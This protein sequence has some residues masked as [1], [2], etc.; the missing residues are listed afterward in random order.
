[1]EKKAVARGGC[2]TAGWPGVAATS[3]MELGMGTE[4]L[5]IH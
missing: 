5:R 3:A 4:L 1:M 2:H